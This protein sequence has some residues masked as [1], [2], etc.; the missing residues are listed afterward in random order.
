M[1]KTFVTEPDS[2]RFCQRSQM[3]HLFQP[4]FW[5]RVCVLRENKSFTTEFMSKC[6]HS[7]WRCIPSHQRSRGDQLH[8]E[9]LNDP[10]VLQGHLLLGVL[11]RQALPGKQ[12]RQWEQPKVLLMHSKKNNHLCFTVL[13]NIPIKNNIKLHF[14]KFCIYYISYDVLA[15]HPGYFQHVISNLYRI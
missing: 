14:S 5:G 12:R 8:L 15:S 11:Q 2:A 7:G 6:Y 9:D 1:N 3:K 4:L 13:E 10:S